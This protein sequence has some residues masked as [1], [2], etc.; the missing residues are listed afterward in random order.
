MVSPFEK[1]HPE[2]LPVLYGNIP[3]EMMELP[4]WVLWRWTWNDKGKKWDKPLFSIWTWKLASSKDPK[5]WASFRDVWE[6]YGSN[7]Q[8]HGIGFVFTEKDPFCGVDLD[9]CRDPQTGNIQ[10][11]AREIAWKLGGYTEISPSQTGLKIFLKGRLPA[12]GT[13][14]K[15]VG[16]FDKGRYFCVT[17]WKVNDL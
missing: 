17:G 13:H 1:Q 2:V 10:P 4:Q 3:T 9:D 15:D 16:I 5:T 12:G 6:D 7:D 8:W 14:R 11:W